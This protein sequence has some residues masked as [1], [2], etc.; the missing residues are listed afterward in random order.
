MRGKKIKEVFTPDIIGISPKVSVAEAMGVMREHR[1]SCVVV[2]AEKKPIGILTERNLVSFAARLGRHG[3]MYPV[4]EIMSTPVLTV[5]QDMD[6]YDA[7]NLLFSRHIRHLVV[8]DDEDEAIGVVTQSNVVENL[9]YDSFIEMKKI[10]Q[11]MS[12]VVYTLTREVSVQRALLDMFEKAV[13][14]LV[15][16]EKGKPTGILTERDVARLLLEKDDLTSLRLEDVMSTSVKTVLGDTSLLKAV[17]IMKELGLRRLVVVDEE[18]RIEGLATQTDVVKGLEG[19]YIERLNQIIAEKENVIKSTSRDLAEKT[20]YL[21]NILNSAVDYGIIGVNLGYRVVY[22]NAGAKNLLGLPEAEVVGGNVREIRLREGGDLF[23][24]DEVAGALEN[25]DVYPYLMERRLDGKK[26]YLNI[27]ASRITDRDGVLIGYL[28][29]FA[30]IT[31][32]K[33]A[34]EQQLLAHQILEKKVLERTAELEKAMEGAIQAMA[35]TIEMRDPYTSGHQR[36]VADLA[37]AIARELGLSEKKV[38]GIYMAGLIHDVGKIRVPSG[39]L[40]HPGRLSEMQFAIIKSHP[41]IGY[42]ILKGIEFPWPVAEIV[43]QHHERM[44]GSGYPRALQGDQILLKA[45]IMGVADVVEALSSH[46]PYRPALGIKFALEEI[47]KRRGSAYD[48]DVVDACMTL[49]TQKAY[50]LPGSS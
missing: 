46:R 16:V 50:N 32:R 4:R 41:E 44:D 3:D 33:E 40:C 11:V 13:S 38:E 43:L 45:R 28:F 35:L 26:Q 5:S 9:S 29:M 12:K 37:A 14:C 21:D 27:R 20:M 17:E 42:D 48:P 6:I 8:V 49:F 25:S 2:L 18:G 22:F 19:K 31:V 7:Y 24:I 30:D 39:I 47:S 10:S 15:V 36:R 1:I 34:E 23:R